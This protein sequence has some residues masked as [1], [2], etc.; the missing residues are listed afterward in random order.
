MKI[1][2]IDLL[3]EQLEPIHQQDV[4]YTIKK[5]L[6]GIFELDNQRINAFKNNLLDLQH[7]GHGIISIV[8][9]LH[10]KRLVQEFAKDRYLEEIIFIHPHT[11]K[12]LDHSI[13]DTHFGIVEFKEYANMITFLDM[14]IQNSNDEIN[15]IKLL[16]NKLALHDFY[17]KIEPTMATQV[18]SEHTGISFDAYQRPSLYVDCYHQIEKDED[19]K[20]TVNQ[21][22]IHGIKGYATFFKGSPAVCVP[23]VNSTKEGHEMRMNY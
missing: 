11:S 21:L 20:N 9:Q 15:F 6:G 16:D 23:C 3:K 8:G 12:W 1:Q 13:N 10:Y 19:I 18:L 14:A 5:R 22:T 2:G 4:R 7:Q 17:K